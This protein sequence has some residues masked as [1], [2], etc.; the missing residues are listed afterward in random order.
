LRLCAETPGSDPHKPLVFAGGFAQAARIML[1]IRGVVLGLLLATMAHAQNLQIDLANLREDVRG[2]SQRLSE[3][4]LRLEQVEAENRDLR[5]KAGTA[6]KNYATLSQLN[7]SVADLNRTIKTAT[8]ATKTETMQQVATQ[9]D[10][11]AKQ[12]NAAIDA[13]AK[14]MATRPTVQSFSDDYSKEGVSYTV[15]KGDTL[16]V[17][18]KKTGAKQQDIINANKISDPSKIQ[19]GQTLFIPGGK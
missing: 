13:L 15:V 2:L 11:L 9:I 4:T 18:A 10:R 12:T 16:A 17:I 19:V 14:N 1:K 5:S 3:L 6:E 8:T 7:D